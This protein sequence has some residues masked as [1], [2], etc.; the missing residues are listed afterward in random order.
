[1]PA[2]KSVRAAQTRA[3]YAW[4]VQ[5][6]LD[7]VFTYDA[8]SARSP[9]FLSR[10]LHGVW[11]FE[12]PDSWRCPVLRCTE[13]KGGPFTCAYGRTEIIINR[14]QWCKT[15]LL[16]E[17]A[18]ALGN[19]PGHGPAYV[20]RFINLMGMYTRTKREPMIISAGLYGIL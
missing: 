2:S 8:C 10:F 7:N 11:Y 6:S 16:H 5:A 12:A 9:R 17:I 18:H 4:T 20:L 13:N 19:D 14:R 15:V 3:V 1:M